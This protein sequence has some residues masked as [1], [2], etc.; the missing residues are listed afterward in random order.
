[1]I[2]HLQPARVAE[3]FHECHR[4]MRPGGKLILITPNAKDLRTTERFWLDPSH[5]RPYPQKLLTA[6][7]ADAGF[8]HVTVTEDREPSRNFLERIV[9]L[10][11]R[12]WF[13]GYM[14]R[15]DLVVIAE[16]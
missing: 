10:L 9:K 14:F 5:V 12:V 4:A 3:L 15:G 7:L 11:I 8:S 2:E 13:L 6:M 16:R 1:V